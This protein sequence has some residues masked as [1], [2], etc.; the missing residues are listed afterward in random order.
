[1]GITKLLLLR[2]TDHVMSTHYKHYLKIY[3]LTRYS[4]HIVGTILYYKLLLNM[5]TK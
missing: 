3:Q 1:M 2:L 4:I 5:G